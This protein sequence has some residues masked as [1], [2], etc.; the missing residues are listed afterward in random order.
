MTALVSA[1]SAHTTLSVKAVEQNSASLGR[2]VNQVMF[3][4]MQEAESMSRI[5]QNAC[6]AWK[7]NVQNLT[8]D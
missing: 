2:L 6:E 7:N 4:C 5:F 1:P 8:A 3:I